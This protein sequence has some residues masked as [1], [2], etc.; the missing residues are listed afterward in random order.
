MQ[1]SA[2]SLRQI[3]VEENRAA[4]CELIGSPANV[5]MPSSPLRGLIRS[6]ACL[7]LFN[8]AESYAIELLKEAGIDKDNPDYKKYKEMSRR[9]FLR[10]LGLAAVGAVAVGT[11]IDVSAKA[12]KAEAEEI[13]HEMEERQAAAQRKKMSD[14]GILN[15][16]NTLLKNSAIFQWTRSKKRETMIGASGEFS[17]PG[18]FPLILDPDI[19]SLAVL[20]PEYGVYVKVRDDFKRQMTEK[21][22]IPT[23][24]KE[25]SANEGASFDTLYD[26]DYESVKHPN[27]A[28]DAWKEAQSKGFV[29][30]SLRRGSSSI[31]GQIWLPY[32]KLPSSLRLPHAGMTPAELYDDL[33]E[34]Y[35]SDV[36]ASRD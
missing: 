27:K 23:P 11:G 2:G 34:K 20:S 1:I 25:G 5:P 26:L 3:I 32:D 14:K 17:Q 22:K 7:T 15:A 16:L 4:L 9:S 6:Q 10:N 29:G 8:L 24:E 21:E 18:A 19:G 31:H 35:V 28:S 36:I 13:R 30:A 33:W 12:S